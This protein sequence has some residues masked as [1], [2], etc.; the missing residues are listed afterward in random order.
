MGFVEWWKKSSAE[1]SET[2]YAQR[3]N[4]TEIADFRRGILNEAAKT[5][6]RVRLEGVRKLNKL[7]LIGCGIPVILLMIGLASV[8]GFVFF[9]SLLNRVNPATICFAAFFVIVVSVILIYFVKIFF[10]RRNLNRALAEDL[11]TSHVAKSTGKVVVVVRRTRNNFSIHYRIDGVEFEFLNDALGTEIHQ[12][13]FGG[14]NITNSR[15]TAEIY[16]F[17]HLPQSKLILHYERVL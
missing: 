16:D 6:L 14:N 7:V 17:Y 4:E 9:R 2:H 10:T 1:A 12:H 8:L 11:Q 15:Q 13:F 5:K 3:F